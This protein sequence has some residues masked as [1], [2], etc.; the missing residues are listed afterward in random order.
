MC[1]RRAPEKYITGAMAPVGAAL[2]RAGLSGLS[3]HSWNLFF[4]LLAVGEVDDEIIF[5]LRVLNSVWI[6]VPAVEAKGSIC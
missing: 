6:P 4:H 1:L 2:D 3:S 5:R